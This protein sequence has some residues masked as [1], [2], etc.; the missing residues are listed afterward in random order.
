[1]PTDVI[2]SIGSGGGRDYSTL[3]AWEDA[4]PSNLVSD[5]KRWIG[6]CYNDSEFTGSG[7]L[8]TFGGTTTD[9]TRYIILRCATGHS[10]SDNVNRRGNALYYNQANGVAITSSVGGGA[11][12]AV[13]IQGTNFTRFE[14]LQIK[15]TGFN[16][17]ATQNNFSATNLR[18]TN[19]ILIHNGSVSQD[20]GSGTKFV[21][22]L[23]V[24]LGTARRAIDTVAPFD[25]FYG[26]T[27]VAPNGSS[28]GAHFHNGYG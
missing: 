28:A 2:S 13:I 25:G 20:T 12:S 18:F 27:L 4:C 14:G 26:C 23:I 17:T 7:T 11:Y 8:L 9:S 15:A 22:C 6:E 16:V 10:F 24:Q 21:S 5:D 19:C 1:M 3:Q